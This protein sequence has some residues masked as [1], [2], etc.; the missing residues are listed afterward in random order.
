MPEYPQGKYRAKIESQG[1]DR[2]TNGKEF[3]GMV[4]RP[5]VHYSDGLSGGEEEFINNPFPRT[6]KF[7]LTTDKAR[8]FA[9]KKLESCVGWRG[10]SW[11]DLDP[12]NQGYTDLTGMEI[13]V[14]NTHSPGTS[15]PEKV[16]DN[17]DVQLPRE[18]KLD[19]DGE[20]AKRLDRL[21]GSVPSAPA[22]PAA[23][24]A[25]APAAPT[26]DVPF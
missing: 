12:D 5:T 16:Y 8:A 26:D 19:N 22:P 25:P 1:F 20:I 23:P 2:T 10:D 3:F 15:N 9:R 4:I 14:I 21:G 7:W 18:A 17:F 6:I 24:V 13:E 11:G